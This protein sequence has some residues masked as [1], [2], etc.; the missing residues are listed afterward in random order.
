MPAASFIFIGGSG[1]IQ[2]PM[3]APVLS[4][5]V[6]LS[7]RKHNKLLR[8][9]RGSSYVAWT[10]KNKGCLRHPLFLLAEAVGFEPTVP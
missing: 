1:G 8:N 10:N 5:I 4:E 6:C 3:F 9:L 2:E 7:L